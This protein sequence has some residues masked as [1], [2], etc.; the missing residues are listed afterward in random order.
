MN[1]KKITCSVC[2]LAFCAHVAH[3]AHQNAD[4]IARPLAAKPTL[5]TVFYAALPHGEERDAPSGPLHS[6]GGTNA[7]STS[8][9]S[10]SAT[11]T[12][13]GVSAYGVAGNVVAATDPSGGSITS[14][15]SVGERGN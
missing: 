3:E 8:G 4:Y 9:T 13:A 11:V 5:D 6:P 15:S 14:A 10:I 7:V 12:L 1:W 2:G